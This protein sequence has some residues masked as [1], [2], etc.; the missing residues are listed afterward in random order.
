MRLQTI[1]RYTGQLCKFTSLR[2]AQRMREFGTVLLPSLSPPRLLPIAVILCALML[3][4]CVR[5]KVYQ[6]ERLAHPAM[7][8]DVWPGQSA[9]DEHVFEV[10]EAS[11]G[12]TGSVGG[13]CGCN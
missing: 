10:R 5:V 7:Q 4:G 3:V 1:R 6:R 12:A 13:G 2:L 9:A 11:K 8:G